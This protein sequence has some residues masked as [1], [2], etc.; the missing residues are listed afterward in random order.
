MSSSRKRVKYTSPNE[1][2]N[3]LMWEWYVKITSSN[4]PVSGR[5]IQEKASQLAV[6]LSVNPVDYPSG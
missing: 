6:K 5:I 1:E 3:A 2:L 4:V